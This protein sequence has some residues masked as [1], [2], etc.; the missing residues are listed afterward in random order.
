MTL[1]SDPPHKAPK[2]NLDV[3][4]TQL[5]KITAYLKEKVWNK[6]KKDE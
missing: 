3:V 2:P 4:R 1:E 6:E 5:L